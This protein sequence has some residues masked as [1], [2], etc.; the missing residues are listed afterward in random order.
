M[1]AFP[2][3]GVAYSAC[4]Y[5]TELGFEGG[6]RFGRTEPPA[7]KDHATEHISPEKYIYR[8]RSSEIRVGKRY[9]L[10]DDSNLIVRILG[11]LEYWL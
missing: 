3:V 7:V 8:S 1:T 4:Q 6:G 10:S 11:E 2:V 9:Y 5:A